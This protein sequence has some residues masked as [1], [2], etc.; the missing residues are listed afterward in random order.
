M[1]E[2]MSDLVQC[3]LNCVLKSQ[4]KFLPK[5]YDLAK[6][7]L[8]TFQASAIRCFEKLIDDL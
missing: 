5:V 1:C 6:Q 3:L 8:N 2:K 4:T 7:T